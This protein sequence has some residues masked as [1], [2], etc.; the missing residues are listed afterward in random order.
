MARS[1][2]AAG[3]LL[4]YAADAL[5][6]DP[7]RGHPVAAFGRLARSCER[8]TYGDSRL[9]GTGHAILLVGGTAALGAVAQRAVRRSPWAQTVLAAVATW[10]VLGGR[11]LVVE[12]EAM[13][14]LL[15]TDDVA[16]ARRRLSHLCSR[17]ASALGADD[18]ARA[19]LESVAENTSDAVVAPLLWGAVAG[20]PGLLGYRAVNTLD[21]MV[22]Y[23]TS[24]Y[25]NFG[26]AC[27]R[28]DDVANWVPARVAA[29]LCVLA[30]P[31]VGGVRRAAWTVWL[32]DAPAHPS[33]NAGRVEAAFA[34]ALGVRLGGASVYAGHREDRGVLD[35]GRTA[36]AHDLARASSLSRLVGAG[37]AALAAASVLATRWPGRRRVGAR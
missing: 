17:D 2:R 24:R 34:G 36:T 6:G 10:T 15:A 29:A 28:L 35:G 11:S 1:A 26:W 33:P 37:S 5:L 3:L 14:A 22:G 27:A 4:G 18:L 21:A 25:A 20:V 19:A 13:R 7:R 32:R 12:A 16:R 23:R 31:V 30:A 8:V 9:R